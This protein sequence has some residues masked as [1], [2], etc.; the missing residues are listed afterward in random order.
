M[1]K[2]TVALL[3]AVLLLACARPQATEPPAETREPA[4]VQ[5]TE[6]PETPVIASKT[7][8]EL[9][10][11]TWKLLPKG[12]LYSNETTGITVTF[13]DNKM[14][15]KDMIRNSDSVS[16][17]TFGD[18]YDIGENN[19]TK[20][21]IDPKEAHPAKASEAEVLAYPIDFQVLYANHYQTEILALRELG[22]GMSYFGADQLNIDFQDQQF[23]WIFIREPE[24]LDEPM[25][26]LTKDETFYAF[27]W[28]RDKDTISLQKVDTESFDAPMYEEVTT[29][30]KLI[31]D[32]T[33]HR[34]ALHYPVAEE[35]QWRILPNSNMTTGSLSPYLVRVTTDKEGTVTVLDYMDYLGYGSYEATESSMFR[36]GEL[37]PN[38]DKNTVFAYKPGDILTNENDLVY[39]DTGNKN[40]VEVIFFTRHNLE[41]FR[42][43]S[44]TYTEEGAGG[45]PVFDAKEVFRTDRFYPEHPISAKLNFIGS[46]PNNGICY[47]ESD[48][49]EKYYA[50]S[51]SG[52]DGSYVLEEI[53]INKG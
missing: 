41:N 34:F 22:N 8:P 44:L 13:E 9:L 19:L 6:A 7:L 23:F 43:L 42:I 15:V 17:V 26:E 16:E 20:I 21:T 53:A 38:D 18:I 1:K 35:I 27:C 30:L 33:A 14:T 24:V 51:Q 47:T 12:E 29:A 32:Y 48:G 49:T 3:S 31:P 25:E 36:Y 2:I 10:Q 46:I 28:L 40:S 50:L 45:V 4:P 39:A 52:M 37:L 11:G 5:E